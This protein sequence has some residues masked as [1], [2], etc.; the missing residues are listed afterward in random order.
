VAEKRTHLD[1]DPD[2]PGLA[3]CALE[4]AGRRDAYLG[5]QAVLLGCG[6]EDG[7]WMQLIG[8]PD[9]QH[10]RVGVL[11]ITD[12]GVVAYAEFGSLREKPQSTGRLLG[13]LVAGKRDKLFDSWTWIAHPD[14]IEH[15]AVDPAVD[16]IFG[17]YP[18]VTI[19]TRHGPM[20]FGLDMVAAHIMSPGIHGVLTAL[21]HLGG[22][23]LEIPPRSEHDPR[24]DGIYVF[25]RSGYNAHNPKCFAFR[26]GAMV[27][28]FSLRRALEFLHGTENAEPRPLVELEG[29]YKVDNDELIIHD[30]GLYFRNS[31]W[32]KTDWNDWPSLPGPEPYGEMRFVDQAR[33]ETGWGTL[34]AELVAPSW[35]PR[36]MP[37]GRLVARDLG[38]PS[39]LPG[40]STHQSTLGTDVRLRE[41]A[42]AEYEATVELWRAGRG[43][44][45][46]RREATSRSSYLPSWLVAEDLMQGSSGIVGHSYLDPDDEP[47]LEGELTL[48]VETYDLESRR[49]LI[50]RTPMSRPDA[51]HDGLMEPMGGPTWSEITFEPPSDPRYEGWD[52]D[53]FMRWVRHEIGHQLRVAFRTDLADFGGYAVITRDRQDRA[54]ATTSASEGRTNEVVQQDLR[55]HVTKHGAPLFAAHWSTTS[56]RERTARVLDFDLRRALTFDFTVSRPDD[57]VSRALGEHTVSFGTA[58]ETDFD[59]SSIG[60]SSPLAIANS[61]PVPARS[62]V[63]DH[64]AREATDSSSRRCVNIACSARDRPTTSMR[65]DECGA[66]T[67]AG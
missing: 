25:G 66:S 64:V 15:V 26:N 54:S 46:V 6:G 27:N 29:R 47:L 10:R 16:S 36:I 33:I 20:T 57:L 14:E 52:L 35:P 48:V 32:D 49:G 23:S 40:L 38:R 2:Y 34:R 60:V 28:T 44:R 41:V 30:G 8:R 3:G 53:V 1:L 59:P 18:A 22:A 13:A 43:R 61:G 19:T 51:R 42:Y 45:M 9:I 17:T 12:A 7:L 24:E 67:Q 5:C 50:C 11:V 55:S 65:C 63:D 4:T 62:R 21:R 58:T 39:E 31:F 56:Q 37:D